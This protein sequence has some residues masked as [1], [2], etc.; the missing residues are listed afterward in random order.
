VAAGIETRHAR[1][2]RTRKGGRCDCEPSYRVRIRLTDRPAVVRTFESQAEAASWRKDAQLNLRR[3]RTVDLGGRKTL[4]AVAAEW[5]E[6]AEA[7]TVRARGGDAYKP[8][9]IR[10]YERTLRL[11]VYGPD[12]PM[13]WLGGEPIEDIRRGDLQELVD[14]LTA[15]GIAPKTIEATVIPLKAILRRELERDRLKVNPTVGLVLPR[16]EV[17]R[18]RI[19]DPVEAAALIAAAPDRDRAVWATAMYAGMRRGELRAL[20]VRN[21][22]LDANLLRVERGWDDIEGEISTKGRRRRNVP[23]PS[24]LR[25]YLLA[26]L[27]RTGRRA[28]PDALVFGSTDSEPFAPRDLTKR[29]DAAWTAAGLARITLHEGRHTFAS[30]MIA[31]GVNAKALSTYMG[32][33]S[34]TIT[35]DRYGHLFPGAEDEAAG[36]L[37]AYL[38]RAGGGHGA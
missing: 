25:E 17:A 20:R 34:I 24:V 27:M 38:T 5:L 3:G 28:D 21:I 14:R 4:A 18:D 10:S 8:S 30:Y 2:C 6:A 11:R 29:A 19:A 36:L 23:I 7:G 12:A 35:L 37:D 33:A 16:G 13:A 9:A 1:S 31:A 22:D 26:H 15:D 32:H